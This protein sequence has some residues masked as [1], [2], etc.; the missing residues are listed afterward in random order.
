M[1]P[2]SVN[3]AKARLLIATAAIYD[4]ADHIAR[5]ATSDTEH[6]D[7]L[8]SVEAKLNSARVTL[9]A[10]SRGLELYEGSWWG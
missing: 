2:T 10:A 5:L 4:A 3:V 8:R 1:A 7:V 6:E 9:E